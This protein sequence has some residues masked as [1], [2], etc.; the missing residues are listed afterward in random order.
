MY[1]MH[2]FI[3]A[4]VNCTCARRHSEKPLGRMLWCCVL[5]THFGAWR[6]DCNRRCARLTFTEAVRAILCVWVK[7]A[8]AYKMLCQCYCNV[9]I[10]T[11]KQT[12][13]TTH[14]T[15]LCVCVPAP[16]IVYYMC[17]P[18]LKKPRSAADSMATKRTFKKR[19][20]PA[21]VLSGHWLCGDYRINL[22]AMLQ[23]LHRK[24]SCLEK[25]AHLEC[26]KSMFGYP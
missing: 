3:Y 12:S 1:L 13:H 4:I 10:P 19:R 14:T 8:S 6:A 17:T 9:T 21:T 16:S 15:W 11:C 24:W 23:G 18:P 20:S 7:S 25:N 2:L 5:C 22:N 26:S